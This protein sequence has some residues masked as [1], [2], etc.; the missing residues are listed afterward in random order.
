MALTKSSTR[1]LTSADNVQA[2][3]LYDI[4][5]GGA[6]DINTFHAVIDHPGTQIWGSFE[7]NELCAFATVHVL[8]NMTQNGRPYALIENVASKP[9]HRGQGHARTAMQAAI[10]TA[11]TA[12]AY[13]IMLLTG[14]D[15]G[16]R[17]FYEKLGFRADQK[18]G[19][20]LR[21]VPPRM[22]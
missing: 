22:P 18:F 21:R 11:W 5:G 14:Q 12:D 13:K 2:L 10:D 20:Q 17:V 16:A 3:L 8:P 19:M 4:L 6:V 1:A 15:T 9:E 7:G